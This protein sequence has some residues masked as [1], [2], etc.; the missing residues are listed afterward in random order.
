MFCLPMVNFI[1]FGTSLSQNII[2]YVMKTATAK[3][4]KMPIQASTCGMTALCCWRYHAQFQSLYA[5]LTKLPSDRG[6]FL[7]VNRQLAQIYSCIFVQ[8][9]FQKSIDKCKK[10][11]YN[12]PAAH[13]CLGRNFQ[14]VK[15]SE[16]TNLKSHF[17]A[18]RP[19]LPKPRSP[20]PET[21]Y[22]FFLYSRPATN[23]KAG[24]ST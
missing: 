4:G 3:L 9:F 20:A 21:P 19:F 2:P 6:Q 8:Y 7:F 24:T 16:L 13:Q 18:L 15:W 22:G 12:R 10:V 11:W 5:R 14:K 17:C 23:A 1:T